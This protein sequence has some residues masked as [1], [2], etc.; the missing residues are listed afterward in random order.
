MH[1]HLRDEFHFHRELLHLVRKNEA[2]VPVRKRVLLPVDE[3]LSADDLLRIAQDFRPAM[4][5]RTQPHNM[6][7]V[8]DRTVV[9][10]MRAMSECDVNGHKLEMLAGRPKPAGA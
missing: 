10:V 6:R 3:R 8:R 2:R 1:R 4:R 7:S 9:S 5:S